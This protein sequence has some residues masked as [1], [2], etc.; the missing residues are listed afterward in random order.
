MVTE[1]LTETRAK[2]QTQM[3][4]SSSSSSCPFFSPSPC[5]AGNKRKER[6]ASSAPPFPMAREMAREEAK[7]GRNGSIPTACQ[8]IPVIGR[9]AVTKRAAEEGNWRQTKTQLFDDRV[10][11]SGL[12]VWFGAGRMPVLGWGCGSQ[13]CDG[14]GWCSDIFFFNVGDAFIKKTFPNKLVIL[15]CLCLYLFRRDM[16]SKYP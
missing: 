4:T 16:I 3:H 8:V 11:R 12:S 10:G 14:W 13:G 9:G 15:A 5:P 1:T 6:E 2:A 7:N